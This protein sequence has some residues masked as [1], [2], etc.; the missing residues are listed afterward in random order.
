M[1]EAGNKRSSEKRRAGRRKK[2]GGD[3][4]A[5]PAC[6]D[7]VEQLRQEADKQ[8]GQHSEELADVLTKSAL[9][10]NVA[11]ARML[12]VLA[13]NKKPEPNPEDTRPVRSIAE[14]LAAQPEWRGPIED[15]EDDEFV[16]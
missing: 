8:V 3:D 10:G 9:A 13:E 14:E 1:A 15:Q 4:G 5:G 16:S 12:V 6:A 7:G 2:K 11:S